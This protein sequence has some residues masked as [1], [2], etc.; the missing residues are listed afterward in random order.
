MK[1]WKK[2]SAWMVVIVLMVAYMPSMQVRAEGT[3]W[4]ERDGCTYYLDENGHRVYGWYGVDGIPH[5]ILFAPDGT[6]LK[7]NLRGQTM[8]DVVDEVMKK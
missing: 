8:I 5:I 3:G 1:W 6:I 7:R 4:V 2:I